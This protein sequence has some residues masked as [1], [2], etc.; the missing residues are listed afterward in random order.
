MRASFFASYGWLAALGYAA[1]HALDHLARVSLAD[2]YRR[3]ASPTEMDTVWAEAADG[4][5]TVS[6]NRSF[7]F[8]VTCGAAAIFFTWAWSRVLPY[9]APVFGL[10]VGF[11]ILPELPSLLRHVWSLRVLVAMRS[12]RPGGF[13][14]RGVLTRI[15]VDLKE[16]AAG[17]LRFALLYAVLWPIVGGTI[18]LGGAIGCVLRA[19]S[20]WDR[21]AARRG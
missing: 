10:F 5:T 15:P 9:R 2:A 3:T 8:I 19:G 18:P 11:F 17:L 1:V 4:G 14:R 20:H 21:A 7:L 12:A 13:G 6:V 16:S